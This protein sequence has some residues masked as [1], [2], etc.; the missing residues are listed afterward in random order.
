MLDYENFILDLVY[1]FV[2]S[3][4][5]FVFFLIRIMFIVLRPFWIRRGHIRV[6][7]S[8]WRRVLNWISVGIYCRLVKFEMVNDDK[9]CFCTIICYQ[10]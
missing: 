10:R 1:E 5:I 2:A 3:L 8:A 4:F 9:P 6:I 7:L